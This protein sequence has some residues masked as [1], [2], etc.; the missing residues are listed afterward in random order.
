MV[1]QGYK[2][3]KVAKETIRGIRTIQ[4]IEKDI[5]VKEDKDILIY[6]VRVQINFQL[7]EK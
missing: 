2:S 7:A 1:G 5:K 6:R 3:N 4:I